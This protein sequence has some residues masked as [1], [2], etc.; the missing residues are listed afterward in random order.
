[1]HSDVCD[2]FKSSCYMSVYL[3]I[4]NYIKLK[5]TILLFH[6][7]VLK[8]CCSF[9]ISDGLRESATRFVRVICTRNAAFYITGRLLFFTEYMFL[10]EVLD[11]IAVY[12]NI[13]VIIYYIYMCLCVCMCSYLTFLEYACR[14]I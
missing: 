4:I 13:C 1:M 9:S 14:I 7:Q 8:K 6:R 2:M 10:I 3:N 11:H 5:I 12:I